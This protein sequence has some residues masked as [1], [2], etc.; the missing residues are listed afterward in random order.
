MI[1]KLTNLVRFISAYIR[2]V[3]GVDE[4]EPVLR[5]SDRITEQYAVS[6]TLPLQL[7][8][9]EVRAFL[10]YP[11]KPLHVD[12]EFLSQLAPNTLGNHFATW[13]D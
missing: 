9:P 3:R 4:L 5:L 1:A 6:G 11:T 2:L 10:A 12:I 8:R 13:M 7:E